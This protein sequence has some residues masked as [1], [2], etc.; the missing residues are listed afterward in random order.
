LGDKLVD[1]LVEGQWVDSPADLYKLDRHTLAGLDRMADKSADNLVAAIAASKQT[2]LARFIYALGI[3]HVGESTAKDLAKH[4]GD[5][6][7]ILQASEADLLAVRDVG[8][9]VASSLYTFLNQ[10]HNQEVI[11]SLVDSGVSWKAEA[12]LANQP[13]AFAGFTFVLTGTLPTLSRDQAKEKIEAAGGKVTGSVSKKTHYVVAGAEAGS[14][15][16]KAQELGIQVLDED[17]LLSMLN[18]G[19]APE[20]SP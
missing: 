17:A 14:K 13:Q 7:A 2:T 3:R 15:L 10:P 19:P 8:P 9:V 16:E 20:P 18:E 4:F 5:L 12:S 6:P 11:Q 1:Q